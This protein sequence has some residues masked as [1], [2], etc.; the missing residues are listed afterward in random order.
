MPMMMGSGGWVFGWILGAFAVVAVS[1]LAI[2]WH[3][4]ILA[5]MTPNIPDPLVIAQERYAAGDIGREALEQIIEEI[6]RT[7]K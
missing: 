1:A 3:K 5:R 6:L 4:Y 7:E 2:M